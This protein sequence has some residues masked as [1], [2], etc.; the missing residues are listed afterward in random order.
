MDERRVI[1]ECKYLNLNAKTFDLLQLLVEAKGKIV[2]KDEILGLVWNANF[3]E[4]GNITVHISLLRKLLNETKAERFIETVHGTGY[5]FVAPVRS[6][7]EDEQAWRSRLA[8]NGQLPRPNHTNGFGRDSD[9]FLLIC[10]ELDTL[11]ADLT[12]G[13][14][15]VHE[16]RSK[17]RDHF[18]K[19]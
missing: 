8:G 14:S 16:L 12:N 6:L 4:E 17:I 19:K 3:V 10:A 18:H 5:R 11:T 9:A 1:K 2:C 15:R 7:N 13:L